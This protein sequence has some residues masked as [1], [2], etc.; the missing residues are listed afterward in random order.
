MKLAKLRL[1]KLKA[2]WRY[3]KEVELVKTI[4]KLHAKRRKRYQD[5]IQRKEALSKL[6]QLFHSKTILIQKHFRRF[7]AQKKFQIILKEHRAWIAFL[8]QQATIIQSTFRR[9]LAQKRYLQLLRRRQYARKTI[10]RNL[11]LL[12]PAYMQDKLHKQQ[13]YH[14][15]IRRITLAQSLA[16]M[17]LAKQRYKHI[18]LF[19]R[20]F[21]E[22]RQSYNTYSEEFA[23]RKQTYL[24]ETKE[25]DLHISID[26]IILEQIVKKGI[27]YI[28]YYCLMNRILYYHRDKGFLPGPVIQQVMLTIEEYQKERSTRRNSKDNNNGN[29][30]GNSRRTSRRNSRSNGNQSS[31]PQSQLNSTRPDNRA[32]S[33]IENQ[34]PPEEGVKDSNSLITVEEVV[35][36]GNLITVKEWDKKEAFQIPTIPSLLIHEFNQL[37]FDA[38]LGDAIVYSLT[39]SSIELSI[40]AK[41]TTFS[42]TADSK[43]LVRPTPPPPLPRHLISEWHEYLT[44]DI[45]HKYEAPEL[46]EVLGDGDGSF[47]HSLIETQ[48][49]S[50]AQP[51]QISDNLL[52]RPFFHFKNDVD[53]QEAIYPIR[54]KRV[55]YHIH[56]E[57]DR[58]ATAAL[59]DVVPFNIAQLYNHYH[60]NPSQIAEA[61]GTDSSSHYQAKQSKLEL[62]SL[63]LTHQLPPIMSDSIPPTPATPNIGFMGFDDSLELGEDSAIEG[64][65]EITRKSQ[66]LSKYDDP[67]IFLNEKEMKFNHILVTLHPQSIQ[68]ASYQTDYL[69]QQSLQRRKSRADTR[70]GQRVKEAT[71][72]LLIKAE[73]EILPVKGTQLEEETES[74]SDKDEDDLA[75]DNS[76]LITLESSSLHYLPPLGETS[77]VLII[78]QRDEVLEPI[79]IL[80]EKPRTPSPILPPPI[81]FDGMASKIQVRDQGAIS[82]HPHIDQLTLHFYL[83]D[84]GDTA[85]A[86]IE[87]SF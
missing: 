7:S 63:Q 49:K 51:P 76:F 4:E 79:V 26:R 25:Y 18:L 28:F 86:S 10:Y 23:R 44:Y 2:A 12:F 29:C 20:R 84:S 31:R 24:E 8:N 34:I 39:S 33:S 42:R 74:D 41:E 73:E 83:Y 35:E 85:N 62:K 47:G 14:R 43:K 21:N 54:E 17:F 30:C 27:S 67:A 38:N 57:E 16:R 69:S 19:H 55:M 11:A 15:R 59:S 40:A 52:F 78:Q 70:E 53:W 37:R 48:S 1:K 72:A 9:Y 58:S 50:I 66:L 71:S 77:E 80:E 82:N 68:S 81:D 87:R 61:K 56:L 6:K 64:Q 22:Y 46:D 32:D 36:N 75:D 65:D 45:Y 13:L 5:A 3:R 60:S